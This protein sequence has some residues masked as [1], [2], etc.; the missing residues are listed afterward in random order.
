VNLARLASPS[1]PINGI[2]TNT[3]QNAAARVP[4]LGFTPIGLQQNAFDAVYNYNSLQASVRKNFSRGHAFQAAYTWSKNLSNVGFNSS[5]ENVSTDMGQQYGET[6]YSRPQ[7]FVVTYQYELPFKATGALGKAV[8]GW[9]ASGS[10]IIQ[11]GNPLTLF[12]GRGGTI[13]YG[14]APSNGPDKGSSRAQ[15]C[16]G[17]TYKDIATQG[18]VEDRL[19]RVGDP[20]AERFFNPAAFCAPPAIGNGT[21]FGNTGTGIVHGP[22]QANFDFSVTK[23]TRINEKQNVQFRAEFFNLF[24][25]PQFALGTYPSPTST[26]S[27]NQQL[28][29]SS[30]TFG[31]I[32]Q[33]AVNPRLI[34][35]ALRYQF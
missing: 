35:F 11:G 3:V 29:P 33:T 15:L 30:P 20:N 26:T 16:P 6:P 27:F 1:N 18:S 14:A 24:N 13:Y 23:M 28:F 8:D 34:Q 5:N 17:F 19:G 31:V 32:S 10:T 2:T 12:D 25:Q 9:S 4:Y 22:G 21:D 7:R